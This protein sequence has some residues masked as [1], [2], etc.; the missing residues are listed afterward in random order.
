MPRGRWRPAW[1]RDSSIPA[2]RSLAAVSR[3]L[4][5][6]TIDGKIRG[7]RIAMIKSTWSVAAVAVGMFAAGFATRATLTP[8]VAYAQG[9]RVFELRTYTAPEG[10]FDALKTRFRDHTVRLFEKHGM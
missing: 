2:S 7:W 6:T 3:S 4:K 9:N 1:I 5:P 10:K 8:D